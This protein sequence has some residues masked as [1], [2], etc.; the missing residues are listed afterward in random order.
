ML[1]RGREFS[2]ED[3]LEIERKQSTGIREEAERKRQEDKQ[4]TKEY[5]LFVFSEF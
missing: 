4:Q 1:R 2:R 3:E 5:R